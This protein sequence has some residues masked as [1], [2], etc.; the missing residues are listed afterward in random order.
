[1]EGRAI[2]ALLACVARQGLTKTTFDDVAREA[3]CSRA[4][5]YRYFDNKV[6]LVAATVA[7]EAA[8]LRDAVATAVDATDSLEDAL[9][10]ILTTSGREL[11]SHR[12]LGF[13]LAFEPEVVLPHLAFAGGDRLFAVATPIAAAPL[14]R[15]LAPEQAAIAGEWTIRALLAY[16]PS[17]TS[18]FDLT[19]EDGARAL[20][21]EFLLPACDP[22]LSPNRG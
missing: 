13:L 2:D 21:R 7:N 14:M 15:F 4:T 8:H 16:L 18:P 20:V 22:S 1:M 17:P 12:A 5:L 10:A 3:G 9:V 11:A 19:S 6:A